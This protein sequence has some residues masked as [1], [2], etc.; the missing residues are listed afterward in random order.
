MGCPLLCGEVDQVHR[1]VLDIG[2]GI[3]TVQGLCQAS[4]EFPI[5]CGGLRVRDKVVSK[6]QGI[7]LVWSPG[8]TNVDVDA[9]LPGRLHEE[10]LRPV[11]AGSGIPSWNVIPCD[12]RVLDKA[13]VAQSFGNNSIEP[14][15]CDLE[16]N[17][18]LGA[19]VGY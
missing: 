3:L 7:A 6:K 5:R 11:A 2:I 10:E 14:R 4:L 19:E 16:V 12:L 17:D 13:E 1:W 9:A 18:V 8:L 15:D